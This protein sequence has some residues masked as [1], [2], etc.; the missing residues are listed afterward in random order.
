MTIT[1]FI[2]DNIFTV[3]YVSYYILLFKIIL[4]TYVVMS[5]IFQNRTRSKT[6]YGCG[7]HLLGRLWAHQFYFFFQVIIRLL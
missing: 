6:A 1:N 3:L 5:S 4:G 7:F 2:D